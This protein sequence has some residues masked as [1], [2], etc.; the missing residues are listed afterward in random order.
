M[1]FGTYS[2]RSIW[3]DKFTKHWQHPHNEHFP[4]ELLPLDAHGHRGLGGLRELAEGCCQRNP[5]R[6]WTAAI[7]K[8]E[9]RELLRQFQWSLQRQGQ[10]KQGPARSNTL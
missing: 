8:L 1:Q 3:F 5:T 4:T 10:Q 2:E 9:A 7:S 6:R